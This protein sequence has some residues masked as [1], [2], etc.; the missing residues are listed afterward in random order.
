MSTQIE[1]AWV[2]QFKA[3]F[4]MLVQQKQS[5]LLGA[6]ETEAL[7]AEFGYR[8]QIGA[9]A[10]QERTSRHQKTSYTEVPHQRR[11]FSARDWEMGEVI[12]RVDTERMLTSP[13]SSY[14]AAFSAGFARQRDRAIIEQFFASANTG[15]DG[16][17]LVAFPA[18]QQIAVDYV[19][20]GTATNSSLTLGKLRRAREILVDVGVEDGDAYIACTQRE[21]SALLRTLEYTSADFVSVRSLESGTETKF[22]GF[23]WIVLPNNPGGGLTMFDLDGSNHRRIPC[24]SKSGMLYAPLLDTEIMAMPDPTVGGNTR[25]IGRASFGATRL[26][27]TRVV[28]IKCSTSVF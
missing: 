26:E 22:M 6:V 18:G 14:A 25:L 11:R 1:R 28:E 15:K 19:E 7:N 5:L 9:V 23:N 24:W 3:N 16:N 12:D 13:Q 27:E 8:E 10:P 21:I 20:A 17:T 2:A 4:D